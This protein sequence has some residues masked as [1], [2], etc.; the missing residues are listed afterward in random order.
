M[1]CNPERC[2]SPT[3][4]E[5]LAAREN[6]LNERDDDRPGQEGFA[7]T[8]SKIIVGVDG[9]E[10]SIRALQWCAHTRRRT[11]CRN[12]RG[13]CHRCAGY[14]GDSKLP[15]LPLSAA[16]REELHDHVTRDWCKPLAEAGVP[17]RV[18]L[19]D[20]R[21]SGALIRAAQIENAEFMVTGRRGRGG[22]TE[23]IL[24][25][26]SNELAHHLDRPLVLVP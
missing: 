9:S 20:G 7:M 13:S 25:S 4:L 1:G 3:P 15:M 8:S 19:M 17:Y 21:P 10:H 6:K 2:R 26:T 11:R 24:G 23:L 12:R 16:Q 22:F 5:P 18:V 14:L